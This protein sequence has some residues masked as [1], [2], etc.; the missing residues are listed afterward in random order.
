MAT[1]VV[2]E[3][4][5]TRAYLGTMLLQIP[6][7][8]E[9]PEMSSEDRPRL[10]IVKGDQGIFLRADTLAGSLARVELMEIGVLP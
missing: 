8:S 4:P 5:T 2:A 9:T 3:K 6:V 10:F 7:F 1:Q